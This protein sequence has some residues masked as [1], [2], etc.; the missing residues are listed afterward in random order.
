MKEKTPD[1]ASSPLSCPIEIQSYALAYLLSVN[2][3]DSYVRAG[4]AHRPGATGQ[5]QGAGDS[6]R[7][8][9]SG[10]VDEVLLVLTK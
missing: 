7:P 5:S 2:S 8:M 9:G 6:P 10:E 1:M 4:H 3:L